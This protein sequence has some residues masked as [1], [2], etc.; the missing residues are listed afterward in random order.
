MALLILLLSIGL[1]QAYEIPAV[2]YTRS[3]SSRRSLDLG[4]KGCGISFGNS[5]RWTGLRL[6][7]VDRRVERVTGINLTFWKPGRNPDAVING[8][9]AG[10]VAPMGNEINGISLG[11]LAV[12]AESSISGIS[13]G[14]LAVVSDGSLSGI[15]IGGLASVTEGSTS[16]I[17]V[18]GLA[19]VSEGSLSGISVGGLASVTE[20]STSGISVGGLAAVSEGSLSGISIGGLASVVNGGTSGIALGGLA[21]V[22]NN[23]VSGIMVS[24][25]ANVVNGDFTGI[26]IS[27]LAAV[28][29]GGSSGIALSGG[30]IVS[31]S[32]I[33]G[34]TIGG[35]GFLY[36]PESRREDNEYDF[37]LSY[38]G[39]KAENARWLV[40]HGIDIGIEEKL[41]G[42]GAAGISVRAGSIRGAALA[43]VF[44]KAHDLRG[45][46]AGAV[47][48]FDEYQVGLSIGI[49][50]YAQR[51]NGIQ[52]GLINI[53]KNNASPSGCFRSSTRTSNEKARRREPGHWSPGCL[54]TPFLRDNPV[55]SGAPSS[56]SR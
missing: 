30:A 19:A 35:I 33:S 26:S 24:G 53:A 36:T 20:G 39:I 49:V 42:L 51:L 16:G 37:N 50:N 6:N 11:G 7:L 8:I 46:S 48:Y 31:K 4:V 55:T 18:G 52:L 38:A 43:S 40:L 44:V 27:G 3:N 29:A 54:R 25:L 34:I 10:L 56:S 21:N 2:K 47:N 32:D 13:V 45:F 5:P 14:G 9:A 12:V 41:R 23:D 15:S 17:S 22:A 28:T 1:A